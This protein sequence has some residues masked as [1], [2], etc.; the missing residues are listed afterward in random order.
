MV[1]VLNKKTFP[2]R[3]FIFKPIKSPCAPP[4]SGTRDSKS[5]PPF[6]RS[7]CFYVAING[8]FELF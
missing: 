6:K 7:T 3:G 8:D 2:R 1:F 5:S 4:K